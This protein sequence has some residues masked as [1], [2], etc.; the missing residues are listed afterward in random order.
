MPVTY[1]LEDDYL[2]AKID[3]ADIEEDDTSSETG[4][5]TTSL[6]ML[7]SFGAASS[8]DEGYFVIPDGSG[9]LI[10]LQQ[11]QKDREILYRLCVWLRCDCG[12]P[13]RTGSDRAGFPAHVRHRQRR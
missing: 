5:L 4:K 9:A 6:S 12:S 13:D 8:T 7:S 3:T 10:P 2:E 1:T 11:R